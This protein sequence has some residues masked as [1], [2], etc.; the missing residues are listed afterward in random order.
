MTAPAGDLPDWT[1][2][3]SPDIRN[4]SVFNQSFSANTPLIAAGSPFRIWGCWIAAVMATDGTY[5]GTGLNDSPRLVLADSSILLAVELNITGAKDK[6]QMFGNI[7]FEGFTPPT[8]VSGYT[9]NLVTD[10]G[11]AGAFLHVACGF[12]YSQP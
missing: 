2:Q 5:A 9:V 7:T 4:L 1:V 11:A 12:F 10:A 6:N 3:T 8:G